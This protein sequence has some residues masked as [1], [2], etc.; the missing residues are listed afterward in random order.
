MHIVACYV[1]CYSFSKMTIF[2]IA[3]KLTSPVGVVLLDL[4]I[5]IL[6]FRRGLLFGGGEDSLIFYDPSRT[7]QLYSSV[8]Y[9]IATGY[10]TV[11]NLAHTPFF[12]LLNLISNYNLSSVAIQALTF[13][14]LVVTGCL[15]AYFLIKE[16]VLEGL[17]L[18][19]KK[20]VP[21]LAAAFYLLNPYT[22]SQLWGRGLGFQFFAFAFIP[23]F[24]LLFILGLKKRNLIY[25][26]LAVAGSFIFSVVYTHPAYVI[27]SWA[28]VGLFWLFYATNHKNLKT[29]VFSTVYI[30]I[31]FVFWV[32]VNWFWINPLLI[33]RE[34][35]L[36]VSSITNSVESLKGVSGHTPLQ[37]VIRLM[38]DG[39]YFKDEIYGSHYNNLPFLAISWLVPLITLFS[40]RIIKKTR[41]FKFYF[42]LFLISL[43]ISIGA[44]FPTGWLLIWIFETFPFIQALRNP[45]EKFGINL[46]IAYLPFFSVGLLIF[47]ERVAKYFKRP[48]LDGYITALLIFLIAVVFVWPMWMGNFAGG[49]KFNP[50]VG[51]P[52]YYKEADEWLSNRS[53]GYFR[54][55]HVPLIPGDGVRYNWKDSFQGIEPSH[56]LFSRPS[57]SRDT[58]FNKNYYTVLVERFGRTAVGAYFP[59]RGTDNKDFREEHLYQELAKLNV[60]YIVLHNDI[61]WKFSGSIS[62]EETKQYLEKQPNISKVEAFGKLDIYRVDYP[63]NI[64]LIYSPTLRTTYTEVNN[65]HYIVNLHGVSTSVDLY[66]LKLFDP[67]WYAEIDDQEITTHYKVFS[68]A[69][70]WTI[71]RAGNYEVSIKYKPQEYFYEGIRVSRIA[72]Y[73]AGALIILLSLKK[74]KV[75]KV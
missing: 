36:E 47:S 68:Y 16:T 46:L 42:S 20:V 41:Y 26:L 39:S 19:H 2:S 5:V 60:R 17:E 56:F 52:T 50:W 10:Q 7:Y 64:G 22:M 12:W 63:A 25:G 48:K 21:F 67:N 27:T 14:F 43:F 11:I 31:V 13:F 66:F 61:D 1:V 54:I 72:L 3:S 57:I 55:L 53:D 40:L 34:Q 70:G 59:G 71:N 49:Y 45:Y 32:F 65:T 29:L 75:P 35:L 8:W 37:T 6:W 51:V 69:N 33:Q 58:E 15:S 4:L 18:K 73:T 24:L 38:H 23:L 28:L 30:I 62:P 44:N 74:L 9:E